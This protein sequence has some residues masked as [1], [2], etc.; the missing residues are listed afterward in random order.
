MYFFRCIF[1][2]L[3]VTFVIRGHKEILC[4]L[5]T[6]VLYT[7]K[8]PT[9]SFMESIATFLRISRLVLWG[10]ELRQCESTMCDIINRL[11]VGP[12]P[13]KYSIQFHNTLL[14]PRHYVK[15]QLRIAEGGV[16]EIFRDLGCCF[17]SLATAWQQLGWWCHTRCRQVTQVNSL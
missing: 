2:L 12:A 9:A 6:P 8:L 5:P 4:L 15:D 17:C 7:Q 3:S 13:N 10:S 1:N 14:I 16:V 11:K